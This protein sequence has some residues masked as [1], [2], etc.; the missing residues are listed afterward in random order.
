MQ[1]IWNIISSTVR[2]DRAGPLPRFSGGGRTRDLTVVR[3]AAAR[4]LRLTVDPRDGVVRLSLGT[5]APIKPALSWAEGKRAWV[6]GEL[7]RLPQPRPILPGMIV[8]LGGDDL[9]LDWD[10]ARRRAPMVSDGVLLVGGP[11]D[12]LAAR[13]L[14]F[15]RAEALRVLTDETRALAAAHDI[16]VGAVGVGDPRG[17]W[18]SCAASGDIRYSWRLVLAPRFVLSATVA[19]EVAHRV[20]MNHGR[21]FHRLAAQLNGTDP[22]PAR[23]WLRTHGAALH[24]FGR[25]G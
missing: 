15:L 21:D 10:P 2:S 18:G 12:T 22:G 14:R 6:E 1:A 7:A 13:V 25:E 23:A 4:G 8:P 11:P 5:R 20:H 9:I 17:R 16:T 19:H 3:R 24:W